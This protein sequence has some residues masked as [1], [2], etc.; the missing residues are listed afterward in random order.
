LRKLRWIFVEAAHQA[1]KEEGKIQDLY[2]RVSAKRGHNR[3]VV[4]AAREMVVAIFWML[5]RMEP[6]HASGKKA[7]ISLASEVG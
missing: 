4:A 7:H 5:K 1:I 6:Y 3:G 2:L